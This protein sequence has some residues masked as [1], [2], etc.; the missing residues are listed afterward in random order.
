MKAQLSHTLAGLLSLSVLISTG[1]AGIGDNTDLET[2][3]SLSL[4]PSCLVAGPGKG[5]LVGLDQSAAPHLRCGILDPAGKISSFPTEKMATADAAEVVP[6]HAVED[7]QV[8]DDGKVW[9]LDNGRRSEAPAKVLAWDTDK[10]TV[11]S[12]YH[13]AAPAVVPGSFLSDLIVDPDSPLIIVSDPANGSNA[14]LIL[15][16]RSSGISRRILQ[17]H[18]SLIPDR[19][20]ALR[21]QAY[22]PRKRLDGSATLP[23]TGV[24]ALGLD[25]GAKWLYYCPVQ[26]RQL[27]RLPMA[28]LRD[29]KKSEDTLRQAIQPYAQIGP[30]ISFTLDEKNNAYIGDLELQGIGI[31]SGKDRNYSPFISDTRILFPNGLTFGHDGKLY[32]FSRSVTA[33]TSISTQLPTPAQHSI[34]RLKPLAEGV[35]GR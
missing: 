24:R 13:I 8:T 4:G 10:Q 25:K 12:L 29:R 3:Y 27:Y 32:F 26:T 18:S 6:L 15:L 35:A 23:H 33:S 28:L 22:G 1:Q 20:V 31:V 17:G 19:S 9:I 5:W 34:F 16:D 21:P 30:C 7:L 14:A 2:V 11:P